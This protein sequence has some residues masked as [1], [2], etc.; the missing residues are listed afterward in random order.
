[1]KKAVCLGNFAPSYGMHED[2]ALALGGLGWSVTR[3]QTNATSTRQIVEACKDAEMLLWI[4]S[5]GRRPE[6]NIEAMLNTFAMMGIET[7]G[8]HFDLHW[9]AHEREHLVGVDPFWKCKH[10][11]TCDKNNDERF[12][13]RGVNHHY[14]Q[15]AVGERWLGRGKFRPELACD[16]TFVGVRRHFTNWPYRRTLIEWLEE[17]YGDRFRH[18]GGSS[19]LGRIWGNDLSDLYASAKVVVG[20]ACNPNFALRGYW[21]DRI[22]QTLGRGGFLIHPAVPEMDAAGFVN[23]KTL[24]TYEYKKLD[25]LK[26]LIDSWITNEAGRREI[27]ERGMKL[28]AGRHTQTHRVKEILEVVGL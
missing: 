13:A 16:V 27:T 22:P 10:V 20:D 25:Q 11:F 18:Y 15:P 12:K 21:S 23:G 26:A 5:H 6:G 19:K 2:I 28:V 14:I 4:G 1:M 9:G 3:L 17:T 7:V 24:V 8:L